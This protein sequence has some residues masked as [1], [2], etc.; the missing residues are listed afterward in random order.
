MEKSKITQNGVSIVFKRNLR[1]NVCPDH[2]FHWHSHHPTD[3]QDALYCKGD[4]GS[5]LFVLFLLHRSLSF[6][7]KIKG[8][9]IKQ[10]ADLKGAHLEGANLQ[11]ANLEGANIKNVIL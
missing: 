7:M 10:G 5:A 9:E 4:E 11:G 1:H 2:L 3:P 6:L 8:Y